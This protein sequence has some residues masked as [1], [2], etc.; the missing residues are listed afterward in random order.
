MCYEDVSYP[1]GREGFSVW[2]FACALFR[3]FPNVICEGRMDPE[4]HDLLGVIGIWM[5]TNEFL[6]SSTI[7]EKYRPSAQFGRELYQLTEEP[8]DPNQ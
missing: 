1:C 8:G 3:W 7:G 6:E 5:G 4:I 2:K